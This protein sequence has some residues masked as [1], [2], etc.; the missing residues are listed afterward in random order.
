M[1]KDINLVGN[2]AIVDAIVSMYDNLTDETYAYVLT[3][4]RR[5]MQEG[6]HFVVAVNTGENDMMAMRPVK[7][8][9]GKSWFAVFTDFE[10]ELKGKDRIMS[11][12]TA[13]ISQIFQLALSSE[14]IQGVILNPWEK[15]LKLDK[16]IMQLIV[17]NSES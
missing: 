6:G 9:D 1:N 14:G 3:L 7:T 4:I 17:G 10:E 2:E 16:N 12:F 5:R 15:P 11:G 13:K 8:K